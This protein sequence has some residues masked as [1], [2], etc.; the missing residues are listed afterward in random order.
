MSKHQLNNIDKHKNNDR[1]KTV[2]I[3]CYNFK[4]E[5]NYLKKNENVCDR[6]SDNKSDKKRLKDKKQ[7]TNNVRNYVQNNK[8][9]CDRKSVG[10]VRDKSGFKDK[11]QVKKM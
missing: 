2:N 4:N 3:V 7:V 11:E 10:K 8:N 9:V 5:Q 6:K 1:S